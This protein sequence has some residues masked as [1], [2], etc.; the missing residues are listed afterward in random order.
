MDGLPSL[1]EDDALPA[2]T[3]VGRNRTKKRIPRRYAGASAQPMD[4]WPLAEGINVVLFAGMGGA[5]QGLEDAGFPVTLAVNHDEIAIAAH[6]ALNPHTRHLQADIYEVDPVES[7]QGQRVKNLWASPDCRDHSVAKGGAPRSPRVRSMPWQVCRW[8]GSLLKRNLG[9]GTAYLENVREVRGWA[10][11]IAKRDKQTGRVLIATYSRDQ[12]T[13]KRNPAP[14]IRVAKKG[15]RVPVQRQILVRNPKAI[16]KKT[17]IGR[18]YRAFV[19]HM[20]R[21]GAI[22]EDRDLNCADY[23]VPTARKRLFAIAR[24]DGQRPVW[25]ERSH[26]SL[27]EIVR[28]NAERAAAGLPA[29]SPHRAAAE[30]IDWSLPLFSIFDR[31]KDLADATQKRIAVG[32][33]RFVLEA[34]KPFLIHLTHQ[35][36]RPAND[37]DDAAPTVT[38]AHRGEMAVV[39]AAVVPTTHSASGVRV[40]DGR[41]AM[42]TLTAGVKGGEFAAMA[43][44]VVGVGGRAGQSPPRHLED[45]LNAST[46]KE[47]RCIVGAT[48]MPHVTVFRNNSVGISAGDAIPTITTQHSDYHPGGAP[49]F[50][51][52]AAHLVEHRG[53]SIGQ[54]AG[55]PLGAQTQIPHHGIVAAHLTKFQEN[56]IGQAPSDAIDTVLAGAARFGVVGA[57]LEEHRTRSIGQSAD[58]PLSAQ[59]QKEHHAV[60]GAWMVQANTGV[61]GH[62]M[63]ESTSTLTTLGTQQQVA[64]A[65]LTEL[66]GTSKDGQPVTD[67]A[68]TMC[69]GGGRGGGHDAVTA[70]FVTEYY[71]TGG[72]HQEIPAALNTQTA[73]DRFAITGATLLPD[74][75]P[76]KI[77][78]ARQVAAFLRSYGCW[79]DRE[80]VTVGNWLVVD[81]GMRMLTPAEAA[82]AHELR[83]PDLI[84]VAKRDRK[85]MVVTGTDGNVVFIERALTKT[86]AMRLVGNS[87]PKRMAMLLVRAN[88]PLTLRT[89]A[90]AA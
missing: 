77:A 84:R 42:P 75:P 60:V 57:F 66:R 71:G 7:V 6:K 31:D 9:P 69:T 19:R 24:F 83:M 27:K 78:R 79:D 61:I 48:L 1:F 80:F 15:E 58:D 86:E 68:G 18:T 89:S 82:A 29:L 65:Y 3:P 72:Q 38:G 43:A 90:L 5:C 13:G 64:A 36:S 53:E 59:T 11:L 14:I 10:P 40:H 50:G 81:I 63:E 51:V 47:D 17:G 56:S 76:E 85:G 23:G 37:L 87:V 39:G 52:V 73:N 55:Q 22:Y 62:H 44:T 2:M 35:G 70:A 12:R 88:S 49:P 4:Q 34:E 8:A 25:P 67:A 16:N 45:P 30:I 54:P 41:N 26:A 33:K 32:T 74:L 20:E 46:T 28:L 21:L